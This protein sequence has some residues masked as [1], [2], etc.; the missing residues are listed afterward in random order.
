MAALSEIA[1]DYQHKVREVERLTQEL[2]VT[3][4]NADR[5]ITQL[6][7]VNAESHEAIQRSRVE[8]ERLSGLL[9][10]IYRSKTWK[11]HTTLEKI[12]GRG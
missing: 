3:R 9:D 1:R 2:A 11:L 5:E 4:T 7:A 12:R 6:R 8:I 10:M